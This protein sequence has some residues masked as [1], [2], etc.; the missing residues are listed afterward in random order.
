MICSFNCMGWP[1][2][3]ILPFVSTRKA[4]GMPFRPAAAIQV[5]DIFP[6]LLPDLSSSATRYVIFSPIF[7]MNGATAVSSFSS[8]QFWPMTIKPL[9]LYLLAISFKC[10]M[11]ARQGPHQVAQNSTIYALPDW[12]SL[13]GSPWTHL[14][15]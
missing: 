9:S 4:L 6:F 2:Q 5:S 15:V 14:P 8:Q 3:A 10:G 12:N 11:E 13:T 1:I 7:L